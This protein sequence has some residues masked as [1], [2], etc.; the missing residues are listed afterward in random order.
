MSTVELL[1]AFEAEPGNHKA[2]EA[3]I[4]AIVEDMDVEALADVYASLPDWVGE[5]A[6]S[7][8]L[9]V[10]T[11]QARLNKETEA[12]S[13]LNFHNGV[14]FW[15]HF[16]DERKAEMSFRKMQHPPSDPEF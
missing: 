6:T 3:L 11:Q 8:L 9:Q 14:L 16:G 5:D 12:G 15:K 10:L 4:K 1:E 7:R 13:L 2:F